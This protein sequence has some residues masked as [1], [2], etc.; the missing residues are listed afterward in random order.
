MDGGYFL[1]GNSL[2]VSLYE[3]SN[4]VNKFPIICKSTTF[5][6]KFHTTTSGLALSIL[7]SY[8]IRPVME[9]TG[10]SALE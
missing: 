5:T 8:D 1:P 9:T 7:D 10:P 4:I 2:F 3:S 6:I